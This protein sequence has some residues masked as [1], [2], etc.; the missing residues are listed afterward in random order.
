MKRKLTYVLL[1]SSLVVAPPPLPPKKY[2]VDAVAQT[3]NE[4][5]THSQTQLCASSTNPTVPIRCA[6][7]LHPNSQRFETSRIK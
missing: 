1:S 2:I 7:Y 4:N 3:D 5:M 6:E